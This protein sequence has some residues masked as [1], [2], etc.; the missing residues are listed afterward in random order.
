MDPQHR[1][2]FIVPTKDRREDLGKLLASFSAQTRRPDLLIVVDGGDDVIKDVCDAHADVPIEY[3]RCVPPG[4]TKQ[5][6]AGTRA[7]PDDVDLVGYLDDDIVLEPEAVERMLAFWEAADERTGG[8]EFHITNTNFNAAS[9]STR[10]FGTNNGD[11]GAILRSGFNVVLDPVEKT[12]EV[13]WL[14]GGATVWRKAVVDDVAH[15]EWF[16]GYGHMDDIDYSV[17]V[18]KHGWKM[19]IVADARLAHYER[20][21]TLE[22]EYPFGVYDTVNRYYLVKKYPER[23]SAAR[24]YWATVGK[25]L[26]RFVAGL[27]GDAAGRARARGYRDGLRKVMKGDLTLTTTTMK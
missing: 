5:K 23:F 26:G 16:A 25:L 20:A 27:R 15:D 1:I 14:S 22:K 17:S 13:A 10:L 9:F 8:A 7:V 12:T 24:W 19:F 18:A 11:G 6:N 4:F 3:L 2:A 21:I